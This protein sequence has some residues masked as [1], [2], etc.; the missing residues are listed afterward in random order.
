[1]DVR[2]NT[3]QKMQINFRLRLDWVWVI[4]CSR[5]LGIVYKRGARKFIV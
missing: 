3:L 5:M 4:G 1:M 2:K